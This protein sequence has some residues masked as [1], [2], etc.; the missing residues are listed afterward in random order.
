MLQAFIFGPI[1]VT[2]GHWVQRG[3]ETESGARVEIRRVD[4]EDLPGAPAGVAGLRILPVSDGIWR[5]DLFR[6]QDDEIIYHYHPHFEAGDVGERYLDE[7]LTA[8][9]VG[10]VMARLADL[11]SLLSDS[12]ARDLVDQVDSPAVERSGPAIR[13]AIIDAFEP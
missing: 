13:R 4:H 6:N 9:P 8:D 11:P 1:A 7:A 10:W 3:I 12:G 5:A 2:V